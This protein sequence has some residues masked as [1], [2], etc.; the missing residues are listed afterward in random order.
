MGFCFV[1]LARPKFFCGPVPRLS[2]GFM[3]AVASM[4]APQ[5]GVSAL[6][7][8]VGS[9]LLQPSGPRAAPPIDKR[10]TPFLSAAVGEPGSRYL[11]HF[12]FVLGCSYGRRRATASLSCFGLSMRACAGCDRVSLGWCRGQGQACC[13]AWGYQ[14]NL[15][16]HGPFAAAPP[17]A[18]TSKQVP[19]K[20]QTRQIVHPKSDLW[21]QFAG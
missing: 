9:E 14:T 2:I 13:G 20:L 7:E 4:A 11:S 6:R 3:R 18:A 15:L 19:S 1:T 17:S 12:C 5:M 16:A 10:G 21:V 8:G